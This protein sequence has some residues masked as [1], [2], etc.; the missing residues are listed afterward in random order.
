MIALDLI[1]FVIS[2]GKTGWKITPLLVKFSPGTSAVDATIYIAR[3]TG[4]ARAFG[5]YDPA[6]P[7]V[8]CGTDYEFS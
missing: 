7:T 3:P 8:R 1:W 4:F 6:T 5:K 2:E